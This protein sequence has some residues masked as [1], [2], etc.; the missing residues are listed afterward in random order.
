M[1]K[2]NFREHRFLRHNP[3]LKPLK[4]KQIPRKWASL[5]LKSFVGSTR[6]AFLFSRG[7]V[8]SPTCHLCS[9]EAQHT[10]H[11]AIFECP[12]KPQREHEKLIESFQ[13]LHP[14]DEK[15]A[16]IPEFLYDPPVSVR[17]QGNEE[18]SR[19]ESSKSAL[20]RIRSKLANYYEALVMFIR[21]T[22]PA[23]DPEL[24]KRT[25][26]RKRRTLTSYFIPIRKRARPSPEPD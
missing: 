8:D 24:V 16:L 4:L 19:E 1:S 3:N 20:D 11:H 2:L 21:K 18:K 5:L 17:P 23:C 6:N 15:V 26:L 9:T 10:L 13:L 14:D 7:V 25:R 12:N 22:Y